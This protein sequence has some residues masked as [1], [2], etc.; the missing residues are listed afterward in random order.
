MKPMRKSRSIK[1]KKLTN[2]PTVR[3]ALLYSR[4][5]RDKVTCGLCE[6]R[7]VVKPGQKGFCGTRMNIEGKLYTLV[8]G[9]LS[10]LESRPI[11]I[12]PFYHFWPGSTALTFSTWSCN[13]RCPWCQN[14]HL[15]NRFPDP[16]KAHFT[17]YREI[18][19]RAL[20]NGDQG[21]CVSFQEP[22]L[23]FETSIE[24]F[25]EAN[26]HGLY[27]T[28]VSNGYMTLEA[29]KKLRESGLNGL[30]IDIKGDEQVYRNYCLGVDVEKVW[31]NARE[32]KEMGIHVEIVHLVVTGLNDSEQK[33][34]ELVNRHIRELGEDTPLHFT[35]YYPAH[36]FNAPPTNVKFLEKAY[37]IAK[38]EGVK[39]P[40]IGNVTG[41]PYENTYCPSCNELLIKRYGTIILKYKL[42]N[43]Y[44]CPECG[45]AI[46]ITGKYRGG[47]FRLKQWF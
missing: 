27:N 38:R 44:K 43:K 37:E 10:A 16:L 21:L 24:A 18:V 40:Y 20:L 34:M 3:E 29:L 6:R 15:S 31:R 41:H 39:F 17:G 2:L 8:Y 13:Y 5:K 7:C 19:K 47:K 33:V 26:K 46:P 28:Y 11:E 35:R 22:T 45:E 1:P 9:D 12:K 30:K 23:L 4:L 32:A 42:T 25:Q 14:F 36:R